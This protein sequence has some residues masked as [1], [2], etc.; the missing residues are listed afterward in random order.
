MSAL[1]MRSCLVPLIL[2]PEFKHLI[3]C[4]THPIEIFTFCK[5]ICDHNGIRLITKTTPI[6]A[7]SQIQILRKIV[8]YFILNFIRSKQMK[9]SF[10]ASNQRLNWGINPFHWF[11]NHT[12]T[13]VRILK[14]MVSFKLSLVV[15]AIAKCSISQETPFASL[16]HLKVENYLISFKDKQKVWHN[17]RE[18]KKLHFA[19]DTSWVAA[20]EMLGKGRTFVR[21]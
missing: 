11:I 20:L 6:P 1:C 14:S 17:W 10:V 2:K 5:C 7:N 12:K 15:L 9:W 16:N 13:A 21:K 18:R 4:E 8:F 3:T 19:Q